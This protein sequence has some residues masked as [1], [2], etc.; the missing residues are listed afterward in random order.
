MKVVGTEFSVREPV[1][2]SVVGTPIKLPLS[3][4]LFH[5]VVFLVERKPELRGRCVK[6]NS[7]CK[8]VC[9]WRWRPE[10]VSTSSPLV[11][12]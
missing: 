4:S 5:K 1:V 10:G 6:R 7:L 9:S 2:S 3:T 8:L 11:F 12:S